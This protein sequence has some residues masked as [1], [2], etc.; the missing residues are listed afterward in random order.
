M[1]QPPPPHPSPTYATS[2]QIAGGHSLSSLYEP[3]SMPFEDMY[4]TPK[5]KPMYSSGPM[6]YGR[7][8]YGSSPPPPSTY[9]LSFG[10]PVEYGMPPKGYS[11]SSSP[12]GSPIG[13]GPKYKGPYRTVNT[14][15][16]AYASA[17]YPGY[18]YG[19]PHHLH[20]N[21][22]ASSSNILSDM[23]NWYQ[24]R[25]NGWAK[26]PP[27]MKMT[28]YFKYKYSTISHSNLNMPYDGY[29]NGPS[30]KYYGQV[31]LENYNRPR[32]SKKYRRRRPRR[33]IARLP[34]FRSL[35]SLG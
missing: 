13:G 34:S 17:H 3:L 18:G 32:P 14:G 20:G 5:A 35:R 12:Y 26:H 16:S 1:K 4:S 27:M 6:T 25:G 29:E 15:P 28:P 11:T 22:L 31:V 19:K 23:L 8:S 24:T 30:E 9:G 10:P 33:I 2:S 7:P 21:I